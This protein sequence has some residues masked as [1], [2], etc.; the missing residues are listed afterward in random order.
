MKPSILGG[1]SPGGDK[2]RLV[3]GCVVPLSPRL[4]GYKRSEGYDADSCRI[5]YNALSLSTN[6]LCGDDVDDLYEVV[7][8]LNY[9]RAKALADMWVRRRVLLSENL[10]EPGV[11]DESEASSS[12]EVEEDMASRSGRLNDGTNAG[13]CMVDQPISAEL[14]GYAGGVA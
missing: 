6:A 1:P 2:F 8:H 5:S 11:V 13:N 14:E 9:A 12:E 7:K 10:S 4:D 3:L